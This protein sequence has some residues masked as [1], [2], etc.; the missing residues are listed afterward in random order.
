MLFRLGDEGLEEAPGAP[1][2]EAQRPGI[3]RRDRETAG[4]W[5]RPGSPSERPPARSN[6]ASRMGSATGS[7][8]AT[9]IPDEDRGQEATARLPVIWPIEAR[10][11]G[12]Q[13]LLGLGGRRPLEQATVTDEEPEQR[14]ADRVQHQPGLVGE[15]GHD[16][17]G[18][19]AGMPTSVASAPRWLRVVM[20]VWRGSNAAATGR[21]RRQSEHQQDEGRPDERGRKRQGPARQQRRNGGG[22][23]Q[24]APEIVEHL[25]EADRR[26][27]VAS[28]A[29]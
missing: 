23:R 7:A 20:P 6:Q 27:I 11:V 25:P 26:H 15:E 16:Q 12:A 28:A 3:G 13:R 22:R 18:L 24:R 2:D 4:I 29:P 8:A 19:G 10:P 14:A 1:R 21:K 9:G 17:A 5:R